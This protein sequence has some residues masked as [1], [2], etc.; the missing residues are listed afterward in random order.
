MFENIL[1][2]AFRY[3]K[4]EVVIKTFDDCITIF[5][6]GENISEEF[7]DKI[8]KPYEKSNR[9]KFGLGMAIV[10]RIC[11]LFDIK[12]A[13]ENLSEGVVFKIFKN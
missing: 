1:D 9:G 10:K 11:D 3:A 2:N 6:D 8:F 13:V 7:I 5:N 12:I 4:N